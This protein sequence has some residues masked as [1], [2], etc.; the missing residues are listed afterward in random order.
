VAGNGVWTAAQQPP[1]SAPV[2]NVDQEA[3]KPFRKTWN[4]TIQNNDSAGDILTVPLGYRLVVEN[5]SADVQVPIGEKVRLSFTSSVTSNGANVTSTTYIPAFFQG[6]FHGVDHFVVN[7]PMR[8]YVDPSGFTLS[9]S[10]AKT[11]NQDTG[12]ADIQIS[13]YLVSLP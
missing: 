6:T 9:I 12:F 4:L 7:Q 5:V 3:R 13:G 1:Y 2:R 11:T 10:V 8:V